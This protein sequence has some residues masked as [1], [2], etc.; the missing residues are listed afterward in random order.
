MFFA[1]FRGCICLVCVWTSCAWVRAWVIAAL[2]SGLQTRLESQVQLAAARCNWHIRCASKPASIRSK[3]KQWPSIIR[4]DNFRHLQS[5]LQPAKDRML[6]S[7]PQAKIKQESGDGRRWHEQ[8]RS[9]DDLLLHHVHCPLEEDSN[10]SSE[11][12]NRSVSAGS[13]AQ[14]HS[15]SFVLS[16]PHHKTTS[17]DHSRQAS[18]DRSIVELYRELFSSARTGRGSVTSQCDVI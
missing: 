8:L 10:P 6:K 15:C 17:P 14:F 4:R 1:A 2:C 13:A 11:V 12:R 18:R 3:P 7:C 16:G 5:S 9:C